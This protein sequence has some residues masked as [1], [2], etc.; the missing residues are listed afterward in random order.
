[1][2]HTVA[3]YSSDS[4]KGQKGRSN[5]KKKIECFNCKQKGHF[6]SDRWASGG[7]KEGQ[8]HNQKGKGKAKA[9]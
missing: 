9:K 5:L 6:K 1:M 8:G 7:R 4:E 2:D 3:L